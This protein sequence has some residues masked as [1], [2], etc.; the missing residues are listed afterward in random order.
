MNTLTPLEPLFEVER[1]SDL[2]L[3]PELLALCGRLQLLQHAGRPTVIGNFVSTLDGVVALND[4]DHPDGG[5]ISGFNQ[6]DQMLMGLLRAIADA[7]IVGAGTLR[8]APRHHWTAQH[9]YPSLAEA[10]QRLRISLG[11]PAPPLNVFVTAQGNIRLDLPVFQSGKVPV[12]IVTTTQGEARIRAQHLPAS[13]QLCAVQ[14]TGLLS[15]RAVLEAVS[16]VCKSEVILVEGGPQLMGD[17]FAERCLGELFLTLAPQVAGRN[18]L[19][20]R[21]GLVTGKQFA[22]EHPLWGTLIS[23]KRGGSHLFLRYAFEAVEQTTS[24]SQDSF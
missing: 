18:D 5:D 12:L 23:V 24:H 16:R 13:V 10:Y 9:I 1:G 15:A 4:P 7:V 20:E 2:P 22:P 8:S 3:P 19:V 6:H 21:P 14:S 17:F 11:K